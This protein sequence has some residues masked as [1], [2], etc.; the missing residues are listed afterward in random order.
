LTKKKKKKEQQKLFSSKTFSPF[1]W[2]E[3]KEKRSNYDFHFEK[4]KIVRVN[5]FG[6]D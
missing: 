1:E 4:F 3:R 6:I 5:Y 2:K